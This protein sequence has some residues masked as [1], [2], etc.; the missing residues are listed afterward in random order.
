MKMPFEGHE[1]NVAKDYDNYFKVLYG[2]DYM[3]PPPVSD[4]ESHVLLE[5]KFPERENGGL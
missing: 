2:L 5:L 3:T 4:R 1:W